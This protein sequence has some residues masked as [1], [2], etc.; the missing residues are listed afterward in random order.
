[1][2]DGVPPGL[3]SRI[4]PIMN[5]APARA[6]GLSEIP[7]IRVEPVETNIVFF[8]LSGLGLTADRFNDLIMAHGLRVSTMGNTRARAVTHL[9]VSTAR[10]EEALAIIQKVV[11]DRMSNNI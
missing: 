1:M 2:T 9:D 5:S 8:D 6:R 10:I 3:I 7:G 11:K 4:E